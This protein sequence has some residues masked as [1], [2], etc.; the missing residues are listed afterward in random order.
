MKEFYKML[1]LFLCIMNYVKSKKSDKLDI[2][3]LRLV[4]NFRNFI[5][6]TYAAIINSNITRKVYFKAF[7]LISSLSTFPLFTFKLSTDAPN[8]E[9]KATEKG[10]AHIE[11]IPYT[12]LNLCLPNIFKFTTGII[13]NKAP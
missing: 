3:Q 8:M 4:V 13:E 5:D 10:N 6:E 2:C 1:I 11:Q 12:V 9:W 7:S